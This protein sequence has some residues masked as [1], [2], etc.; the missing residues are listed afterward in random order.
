MSDVVLVQVKEGYGAHRVGEEAH[1]S[2]SGPFPVSR[3]SYETFKDKLALVGEV[4]TLE[5]TDEAQE[6]EAPKTPLAD[7]D[8]ID[9]NIRGKLEDAGI[10]YAEEVRSASDGRL[11]KVS[12][13]GKVSLRHIRAVVG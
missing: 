9:Q 3:S 1:T 11:L 2:D 6:A 13:I 4:E 7:V 8:G 10:V 5:T 12:G